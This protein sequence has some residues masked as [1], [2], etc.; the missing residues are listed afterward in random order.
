MIV[1]S[2][3]TAQTLQ[4]GQAITFNN[5]LQKSDCGVCFNK[6]SPTSAKLCKHGNYIVSFSGNVTGAAAAVLQ[7]AITLGG[8]PLIETG[9]NAVPAAEGDLTNVHTLTGLKNCCCD[10]DRLSVVNSGTTPVTVAP[11]SAFVIIPA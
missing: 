8:Q 1:L 9:M 2:N 5:V 10:L 7:L 11:N 6:Q 4:P 3:L